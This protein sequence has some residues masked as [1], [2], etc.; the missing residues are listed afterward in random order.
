MAARITLYDMLSHKDE[1]ITFKVDAALA[2]ALKGIANRS[3]FIRQ[4]VLQALKHECPLCHGNGTL[5]ANQMK[6]WVE[7]TRTH[8]VQVC[9]VCGETHIECREDDAHEGS[10]HGDDAAGHAGE[11]GGAGALEHISGHAVM[12]EDGEWTTVGEWNQHGE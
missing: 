6:H 7:F 2:E 4:A 11:P 12:G 10:G 3:E 1:V 8:T 5:T 9:D